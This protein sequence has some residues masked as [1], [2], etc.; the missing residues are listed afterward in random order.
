M[1]SETPMP[2]PECDICQ[3]CKLPMLGTCLLEPVCIGPRPV[4]LHCRY[5]A[6]AFLERQAAHLREWGYTVTRPPISRDSNQETDNVE[7]H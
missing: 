7:K 1:P 3:W 2:T 6:W 4:H 5:E